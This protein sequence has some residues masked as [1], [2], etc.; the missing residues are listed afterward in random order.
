[1]IKSFLLKKTRLRRTLFYIT[2]DGFLLT[3][4]LYV[5]L[6]L[7]FDGNI[8]PRFINNFFSYLLVFLFVKYSVFAVFRLYHMT[9][10]YVGFYELLDIL[11]A[12]L[13]SLIMLMGIV[14]ILWRQNLF[15]GLPSS[16]LLIDFAVSLCLIVMFRT[17]RRTYMQARS[18]MNHAG[19][20]RTL[21]IGAGYAGEQIVR[22]IRRQKDSSYLPVGFIDDDI[23]KR[24][25]YIQGIKVIDN[26]RGIPD[27]VEKYAVDTVLI[28][29][30]SAQSRDIRKIIS[31]VLKS[32]VRDV[33]TIPAFDSLLNRKVSLSDIKPVRIEDIIGREQIEIDNR[34]VTEF[35][36]G[37][38]LLI[39]GAGGSIGSELVRQSFAFNPAQVIALDIDETEL[40]QIEMR[41]SQS[42]LSR[43]VPVV[44]D[45]RNKFKIE[46]VFHDFCPDVVFHAA[47]YKHVP[48]ME[49]YPEEAID[50]NIY[51]TR[52]VAEAAMLYD[53]DKFVMVSTDKAVKPTNIMGAT[54]NVAEKIVNALNTYGKTRFT[55][56]RFGNVLGSRGSVIQIFEEQIRNGGP[57]TVTHQDMKRYFMSI[58]EASILILQAAAMSNG[59]DLYHLD[60][61]EQI[62]I[63]NIARELVHMNGLEPDIDIPIIFSGI[64]KGEKL[65]EEL[66]TDSEYSEKTG[67][68]K[69][70]RVKDNMNGQY[71]ILNEV[72]QFEEIIKNRQWGSIR[73][74]LYDL[75]PTYNPSCYETDTYNIY[76]ENLKSGNAAF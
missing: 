75:V 73:N 47:A 46:A 41:C 15:E 12:N 9:W 32:S 71:N 25:D 64:R 37:K 63:V 28:S 45:V 44:A 5:S 34:R 57:I 22:E 35:I 48:M 10:S 42:E 20:K 18:R 19:A 24:G 67:H 76:D 13:V 43:F 30:P 2:G 62:K 66:I 53:V 23:M 29:I 60:M 50:V 69:I 3:L 6:Y 38:K 33:K 65:C 1:M 4:S 26:C 39:T 49:R 11:K 68:A 54:K 58:P 27:A 72:K 21:I 31:Y 36:Q 7:R 52:T 74:L 70:F 55:S 8:E 17:S 40:Y 59:G 16:I 14:F 51:G 61:G 56:V